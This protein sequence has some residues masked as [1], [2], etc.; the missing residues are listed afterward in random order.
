VLEFRKE[1]Q[2][3]ISKRFAAFENFSAGYEINRAEE[4]FEDNI[5]TSD[6]ESQSLPELKL[7][8]QLFDGESLLFLI[9]KSQ[10][11]TV[12]IEFKTKQCG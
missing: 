6:I 12:G 1:Y 11:N 10:L 7:H 3:E 9:K 4:N 5:E 2:S 8:K